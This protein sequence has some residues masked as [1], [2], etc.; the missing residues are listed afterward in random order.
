MRGLDYYTK[1]AFEVSS[2]AL[3]SQ[4]A[5]AGG[6]RYDS[7]VEELGGPA[8][9]AVGFAIGLERLLLLL[10]EKEYEK[11]PDLLLIPLGEKAE[12][13][14][15]PLLS[16][17]REKKISTHLSLGKSL[18]GAMKTANAERFCFA[19]V[20][21]DNEMTENRVC[22]KHV[23]SG[24]TAHSLPKSNDIIKTMTE[25]LKAHS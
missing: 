10:P 24:E 1:T 7:L 25:L 22:V 23:D 17:L 15:F 12:S 5:V 3:G 13:F 18:K 16:S 11:R 8:T 4:D 2:S 14:C 21:G 6:G 9:E 19:I 20:V